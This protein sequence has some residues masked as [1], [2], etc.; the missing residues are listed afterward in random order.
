MALTCNQINIRYIDK[1]TKSYMISSKC[2]LFLSE[3]YITE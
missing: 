2:K 1:V 3:A